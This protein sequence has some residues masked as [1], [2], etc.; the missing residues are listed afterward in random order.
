MAR[1]NGGHTYAK[2]I[3]AVSSVGIMNAENPLDGTKVIFVCRNQK[4]ICSANIRDI[5]GVSK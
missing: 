5:K 3:G 2:K 1:I 4:P